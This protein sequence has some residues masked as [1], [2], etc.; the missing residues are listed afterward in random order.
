MENRKLIKQGSEYYCVN[1]AICVIPVPVKRRFHMS[2]IITK[3]SR[4]IV[5]AALLLVTL[6]TLVNCGGSSSPGQPAD[7]VITV[8]PTD[9]S[10]LAGTTATFTVAA[11]D[12]AGYQW[13]RSTDGGTTF[14]SVAGATAA[15]YTT[16]AI[17]LADSGTQYRVVVTGASNSVT[18]STVTLTVTTVVVAPGITVQPANQT[19]TEGQNA[20]FSVTATGTSISYQWQRS[21]NGGVDFTAVA[22]ATNATLTLTAVTLA[23]NAH[24]FRVEVSNSAGSV[25]S[26]A[27]TLTV[28]SADVAPAFTTQ[29]ANVTIIAGQNAQFTVVVSGAPTPTLQWQLSTNSGANWSDINGATGSVFDVINAALG[30]NGR[31]FRVVATNSAGVVNSN[32]ATLT[33]NAAPPAG[34]PSFTTH[35]ANVA[36]TAGQSTSF[37]VVV[38][39]T[40]TPTLQWQLRA[41]SLQSW[42]DLGSET[43]ATLNIP[44][45]T[46]AQNGFQVRVVATNSVGVT[47]SNVA[48][49]TVNPVPPVGSWRTAQLLETDNVNDGGWAQVAFNAAGNGMAVWSQYD[50]TYYNIWAS[51]YATATG[52]EA[53]ELV[54]T[55]TGSAEL[56]QVVMDANGNATAVWQQI[57]VSVARKNIVANRYVAGTGWG[58]PVVIETNGPTAGDDQLPQIAIDANGNV[59]AVWNLTSFGSTT[60]WANRYAVG[61]GWGTASQIGTGNPNFLDTLPQ[62]SLD[63]AGNGFAVWQQYNGSI[64]NIWSNRFAVGTGWGAAVLISDSAMDSRDPKIAA[65]INGN[66]IAVWGQFNLATS[67]YDIFANRYVAGAGWGAATAIQANSAVNNAYRPKIAFDAA[68]NAIAAWYQM[69][70][71]GPYS[72]WANRYV[73]GSGW[74]TETLIETND[75]GAAVN[76]SM[77]MDSSGN[78]IAVWQQ[79]DANGYSEIYSNRYVVGTGW[80]TVAMVEPGNYRTG[81]VSIPQIAVNANGKALAVWQRYN[82]SGLIPSIWGNATQ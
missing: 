8:Q 39:G 4:F 6:V 82:S 45:T 62:I 38:S 25:T 10:V 21:T 72:I 54:E 43:N 78:A 68:G 64:I 60:V 20:T 67:A 7:A 33:V 16:A 73:A 32:A 51:H 41:N 55:S 36:V 57:D 35:P 29:P 23:D 40:P 1:V 46:L 76:V 75:A 65:D 26:N 69:G 28:N 2:T 61:T 71:S 42:G 37:T 30:N 49:L 63:A 74:G 34:S 17:I 19:I 18:S 5:I 12:A 58:V 3:S 80:G 9:Q 13:Q 31:Q 53:A 11:T 77:G 59:I 79:A 81:T 56:P 52:W 27:A 15:S 47:N 66:A 44:A 70:S 24:Q 48:T 22:G 50:G 14:T